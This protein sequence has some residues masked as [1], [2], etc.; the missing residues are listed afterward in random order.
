[1]PVHMKVTVMPSE[2]GGF[3]NLTSTD[4]QPYLGHECEPG[5]KKI[6]GILSQLPLTHDEQ[7]S[8]TD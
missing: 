3:D 5:L 7:L 8:V 2:L 6:T 4:S 1:M